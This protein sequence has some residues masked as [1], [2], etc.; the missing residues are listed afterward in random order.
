MK[1]KN[2]NFCFLNFIEPERKTPKLDEIKKAYRKLA[3]ELHPD[4]NKDDADSTRKF[5]DLGAAY[6]VLSDPEKRKTYDRYG[7]EGLK[8]DSFSGSDPFSRYVLLLCLTYHLK[9]NKIF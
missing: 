1:N 3:K 6:E 8:Q 5:Q 9:I 4:K 2:E 7:E